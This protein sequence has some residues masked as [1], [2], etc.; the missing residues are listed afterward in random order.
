MIDLVIVWC[1]VLTVLFILCALEIRALWR[2][3]IAVKERMRT[4]EERMRT[5]EGRSRWQ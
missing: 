4:L 5:L 2:E 1:A 3:N